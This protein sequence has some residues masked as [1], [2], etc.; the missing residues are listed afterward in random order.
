MGILR[1]L[2]KIFA[3]TLHLLCHLGS[4]YENDPEIQLK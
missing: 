3:L 4:A 2:S 1:Q